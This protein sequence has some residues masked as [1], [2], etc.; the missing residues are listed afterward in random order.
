[1]AIY[2]SKE[3]MLNGISSQQFNIMNAYIDTA[4]YDEIFIA[5][6]DIIEI[7]TLHRDKPYNI[8]L[9]RKPLTFKTILA[10]S[11]DATQEDIAS[12]S[13]WL[14]IDFFSPL[15]FSSFPDRIYYAMPTNDIRWKHNGNSQGYLEVE[16]RCDDVCAFSPVYTTPTYDLT[17]NPT[18]TNIQL[19]NNGDLSIFPVVYV[20]IISGSTFSIVNNSNGGQIMS[21]T[22]LNINEN[23][24]ISGQDQEIITDQPLLYRYGNMTGDYLQLVRGVNN[25]QV[26]GNIKIQFAYEFR[27]LQS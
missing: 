26:F 6:T 13:R 10:F 21:F 3:F 5:S 25:L 27:I 11:P 15:I 12:V 1:M 8:L 9:K 18:S 17:T 22:G 20:Q 23:I 19:V 2:E 7:K 24:I 4:L 16:W 14:K